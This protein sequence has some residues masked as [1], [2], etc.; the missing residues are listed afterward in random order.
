MNLQKIGNDLDNMKVRLAILEE[1]VVDLHKFLVLLV[2]HLEL[3]PQAKEDLAVLME[4]K[5][6]LEDTRIVIKKYDK[7]IQDLLD[8]SQQKK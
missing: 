7:T 4:S 6:V 8:E 3:G 1:Q 5:V 2:E